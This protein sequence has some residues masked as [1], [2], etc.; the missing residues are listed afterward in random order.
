MR[1]VGDIGAC[2]DSGVNVGLLA[3]QETW[4]KMMCFACFVVP[5]CFC[6]EANVKSRLAALS[7]SEMLKVREVFTKQRHTRFMKSFSYHLPYGTKSA[8]VKEI[9]AADLDKLA[10]LVKICSFLTQ[11][12]V[13]LFW[14]K[15]NT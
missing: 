10:H 15:K 12:K 11:T 2:V 5:C 13:Y 3:L 4:K 7:G 6:A 9:L 8:Y 14:E 1:N